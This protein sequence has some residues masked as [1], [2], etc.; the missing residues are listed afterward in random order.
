MS[1]LVENSNQ[2]GDDADLQVPARLRRTATTSSPTDSSL[3]TLARRPSRAC[4]GRRSARQHAPDGGRKPSRIHSSEP[5]ST[6]A[7]TRTGSQTG[8]NGGA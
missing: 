5:F 3:A 4:G 7:A 2:I 1:L 6:F 8:L